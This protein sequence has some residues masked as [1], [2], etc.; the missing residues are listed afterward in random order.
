MALDLVINPCVN[1]SLNLFLD[2]KI[3][4][5]ILLKIP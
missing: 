3:F 2:F 5:I 4:K 1:Q